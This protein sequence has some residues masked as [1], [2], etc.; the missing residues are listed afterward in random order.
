MLLLALAALLLCPSFV[1]ADGSAAGSG[2]TT[3]TAV[4]GRASLVIT[5]IEPLS[6]TGRGF[7]AAERVTVRFQSR[8]RATT[9]TSAGRF[10]VR[11][12]GV[13][14]SGGTI[15]AVGSKGSRAVANFSQPLCVAP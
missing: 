6:V 7:K 11:F 1:T 3:P 2:R 13:D 15:V 8:R 9:A 14:C 4:T 5:S 12:A 10:V